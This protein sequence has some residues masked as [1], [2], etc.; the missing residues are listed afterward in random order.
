MKLLIMLS[1]ILLASC[2]ENEMRICGNSCP[3]GMKSY[4]G[5]GPVCTCNAA[6]DVCGD[7]TK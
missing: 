3:M 5:N 2:T 7:K 4:N 6:G 1:L